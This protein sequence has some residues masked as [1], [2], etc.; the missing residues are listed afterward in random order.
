MTVTT[1]SSK[2]FTVICRIDTEPEV[3]YFKNGGI[4]NYA[5]RKLI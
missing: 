1:N 3:E 5:L 2:E 4:L